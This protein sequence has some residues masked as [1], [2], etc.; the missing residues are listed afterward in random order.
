[1]DCFR[2]DLVPARRILLNGSAKPISTGFGPLQNADLWLGEEFG[3]FR[4]GG[5]HAVPWQ[6]PAGQELP[7]KVAFQLVAAPDGAIWMGTFSGLTGRVIAV[8]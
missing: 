4:F 1:M 7:E 5:V 6:L 2:V 3:I 8:T